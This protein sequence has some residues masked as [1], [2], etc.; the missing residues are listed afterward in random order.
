MQLYPKG[1]YVFNFLKV[2]EKRTKLNSKTTNPGLVKLYSSDFVVP[3]TE[4][5]KS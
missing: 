2:L 1:K 5:N 4:N 3:N